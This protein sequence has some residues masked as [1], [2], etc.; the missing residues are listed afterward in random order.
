MGDLSEFMPQGSKT[1]ELI[2]AHYKARADAEPQRGYLGASVAGHECDRFLW[3]TFR[4]VIREDAEGR[5]YRLWQTGHREEARMLDDL[6]AI[7]LKVFDRDPET[8]DQFE[9]LGHGGHFSG[10]MDAVVLGVPEAPKTP[11]VA[12]CKTHKAS[13]FNDLVK[14]GVRASKP[15]H[16]AQMQVYMGAFR[17]DRALYL[18]HNKDTD[19]LHAERVRFEPEFYAKVLARARKIIETSKAPEKCSS[20]SDDWRCNMCPAQGLCWGAW[21]K[22]AVPIRAQTCKACVHS[23]ALTVGSSKAA[24]SCAKYETE[25]DPQVGAECPS[26]LL[27]PGLVSF[28]EPTDSGDDWIEFTNT[29]DGTK[30]RH[31]VA[32]LVGTWSLAGLMAPGYGPRHAGERGDAH[33]GPDMVTVL[34]LEDED[35]PF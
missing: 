12:E 25:V 11:H 9:L 8:Q 16:F 33:D 24:W 1:V 15:V 5:M 27:L 6:R 20:R 30:W 21:E 29:S 31:G 17:I 22:P 14:K 23:T 4:G 32:R 10:H 7:G 3:Y 13:S 19:E 34:G 26:F 35:L 18:A 28:A 2:H